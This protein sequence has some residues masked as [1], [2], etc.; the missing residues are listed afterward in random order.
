MTKFLLHGGASSNKSDDNR[1]FFTEV[2]NSVNSSNVNILCVYFARPWHRWDE[3]FEE[4]KEIFISVNSD[5]ELNFDLA[6]LDKEEL[7]EQI[8]KS[9]IIFINGGRNG[10]LKDVLE[11]LNNF[12]DLIKG[13]VVVGI[14][15]GAN[16][17]AKY[18]YSNV[19]DTIREGIGLLPI[20]TFCHFTENNISELNE[21]DKYKEK[22]TIYKIPEE[23][24]LVFEI[25]E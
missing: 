17:L 19:A 23:K 9:D 15:A 1:K 8:G 7:I 16:I 20:K 18:Y 4:D 21:L 14:S 13:K 5:R 2:L 3:S 22:I 24:F 12:S 11:D 10:C 25:N 6:K